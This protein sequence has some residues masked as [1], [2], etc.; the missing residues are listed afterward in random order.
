[1]LPKKVPSQVIL[2]I[3][4]CADPGVT[5]CEMSTWR[6]GMRF[7]LVDWIFIAVRNYIQA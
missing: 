2:D 5:F 7:P 3:L 4:V 1:M 6:C